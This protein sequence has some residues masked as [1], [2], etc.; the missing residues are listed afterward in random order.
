MKVHIARDNL[1]CV[2]GRGGGL[3]LIGMVFRG[4]QSVH[5]RCEGELDSMGRC[6]L[7]MKEFT[8]P[9]KYRR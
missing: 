5:V 8:L 9:R 1:H 7:S 4:P 6:V 3:P 2:G